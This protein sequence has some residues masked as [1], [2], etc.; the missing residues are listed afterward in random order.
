[1]PATLLM[2]CALLSNASAQDDCTPNFESAIYEDGTCKLF[3][4]EVF[5][6]EAYDGDCPTLEEVTAELN[7]DDDSIRSCGPGS[8]VA[9][10]I[11]TE[12]HEGGY[13][14]YFN[15]AGEMLGG[16][17][18]GANSSVC[19]EGEWANTILYGIETPTC[20]PVPEE[21]TKDRRWSCAHL[22]PQTRGLLLLGAAV[23]TS[24]RRRR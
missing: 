6:A 14:R 24:R 20:T 18:Y 5:C 17:S 13:A 22:Q 8:D 23:L 12:N 4:T 11:E 9:T 19:C 3:G 16:Y 2:Y 1:M 10:I 7:Y 21:D 15:E